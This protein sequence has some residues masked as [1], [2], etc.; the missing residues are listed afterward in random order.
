MGAGDNVITPA[1]GTDEV[2]EPTV[3]G[4]TITN[5]L[6]T[7][8]GGTH[9]PQPTAVAPT[10]SFL[11]PKVTGGGF[12]Q[13]IVAASATI[14]TSGL[15]VTTRPSLTSPLSV[16]PTKKKALKD[17]EDGNILT[18]LLRQ[19]GHKP[20]DLTTATSV[21]GKAYDEDGSLVATNICNVDDTGKPSGRIQY[22]FFGSQ[23][24]PGYNYDLEFEVTWADGSISY[25]PANRA[26]R[27]YVSSTYVT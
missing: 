20:V 18:F 10:T 4:V 2:V 17:V 7:T 12:L 16:V 13:T 9:K 19:R 5:T 24:T 23:F 25:F 14:L 22:R 6:V 15:T 11:A 1:V 26:T 27:I 21:Y 3:F 8:T